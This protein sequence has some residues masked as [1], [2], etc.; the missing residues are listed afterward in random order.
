MI[1]DMDV[2]LRFC[3]QERDRHGNIR[4]YVRCRGKRVRIHGVPGSPTFLDAYNAAI[5][6]IGPEARAKPERV[7]VW[8][9]GS[10][11][12]LA[13]DYFRSPEFTRLERVS[14]AD[15]RQIIGHCLLEL[16]DPAKPKSPPMGEVPLEIFS[17]RHVREIRD[18][19]VKPGAANNRVKYISSM[20]A[21]ALEAKRE[22]VLLN[23]TRDV[24][25]V[26]YVT[27]GFH[28]WTPEE[29]AQYEERHPI[30]T[31]ARLALALLLYTGARRG[32]VVTFGRQHVKAGKL[33]YVP[34]KTRHK[35]I[36]ALVIP[37]L[38]SLAGIIAKSP[39]GN[40]TFL[41][42][43]YGLPFTANGFGG[44]FRERC[45]EAGLPQCSAHGLRKAAATALAEGG[46]TA[47]ELMSIFGWSTIN[48]ATTYTKAVDQ[49]RL[50]GRLEMLERSH[51]E[52]APLK[53]ATGATG[54]D[55]ITGEKQVSYQEGRET[56]GGSDGTT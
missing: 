3:V 11:G 9:K 15:R 19:K 17:D 23:P 54:E 25:P 35:K 12:A 33:R 53:S 39:V 5:A 38:S 31:K 36:K 20:F 44:W 1:G 18:R 32:D 8:P 6:E 22:G 56:L 30:G 46:A 16:V 41:V 43:E 51:S 10:L 27:D 4:I 24:K 2:K 52:P 7:A 42:T 55:R 47:H 29:I 50:A 49:E 37:M 26:Q 14:Q 40:P 45:D 48:Q 21:W 28:T 13:D 34:R